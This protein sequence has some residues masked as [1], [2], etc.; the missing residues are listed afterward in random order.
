MRLKVC[1]GAFLRGIDDLKSAIPE[2]RTYQRVV[3][4]FDVAG[5]HDQQSVLASSS[6]SNDI[7]HSA[8]SHAFH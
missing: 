6:S 5:C 3:E 2:P 7:E 4:L 8:Q 1:S